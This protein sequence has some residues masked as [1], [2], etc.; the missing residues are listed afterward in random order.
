[1]LTLEFI[2]PDQFEI[3]CITKIGQ[4][5]CT[6]SSRNGTIVSILVIVTGDKIYFIEF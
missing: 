4:F 1:M 6:Y 5:F 2:R 3:E